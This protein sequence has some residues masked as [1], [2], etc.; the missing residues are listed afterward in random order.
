MPD[1]NMND[2]GQQ[3]SLKANAFASKVYEDAAKANQKT[4]DSEEKEESKDKDE[5]NVV[6]AD[7]EEK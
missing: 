2:G 5:D 1:I 7:Y 3:E 4:S 6:D